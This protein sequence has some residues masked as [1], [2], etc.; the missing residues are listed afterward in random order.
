MARIKRFQLAPDIFANLF[1]IGTHAAYSV[2]SNGFPDGVTVDS[3]AEVRDSSGNLVGVSVLLE[4]QTFPDIDPG[5]SVP[6][7]IP[8]ISKVVTTT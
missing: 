2:D 8:G 7:V 3:F 4:H 1:T 6:I 5:V